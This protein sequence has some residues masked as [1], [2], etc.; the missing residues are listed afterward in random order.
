MHCYLSHS[1]AISSSSAVLVNAETLLP[2]VLQGPPSQQLRKYA[3]S[4]QPSAETTNGPAASVSQEHDVLQTYL[5]TLDCPA[6]SQ[7]SAQCLK[8]P[9][10]LVLLPNGALR[11]KLPD[12]ALHS[13]CQFE[14]SL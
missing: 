9:G 11:G 3:F 13:I 2:M 14:R 8:L 10:V 12:F 6:D 1:V 4:K 5:D 7:V